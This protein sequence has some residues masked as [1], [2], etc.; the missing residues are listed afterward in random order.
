MTKRRRR[1]TVQE[2]LCIHC[3][4]TKAAS[5]FYKA[6]NTVDRLASWC[7]SCV[8]AY[9]REHYRTHKEERI[10]S[11]RDYKATFMGWLVN[12]AARHAVRAKAAG[13]ESTLT[14]EDLFEKLVATKSHCVYCGRKLTRRYGPRELNW[15]HV[16]PMS[17]GGTNDAT[18]VVPSCQRCNSDKGEQTP[19]EWVERWYEK[20]E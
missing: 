18:N 10:A 6:S 20:G 15:D 3:G 2:K 5:E 11:D 4:E 13:V 8:R 9:S 7:K 12:T 16:T 1:R 14:G 17:R 19:D